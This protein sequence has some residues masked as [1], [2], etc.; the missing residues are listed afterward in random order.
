MR[1]GRGR[2]GKGEFFKKWWVVVEI[3]LGFN[4]EKKREERVF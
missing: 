1:E 3:R 2:E 4:E